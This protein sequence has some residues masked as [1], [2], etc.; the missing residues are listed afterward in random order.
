MGFFDEYDILGG[1]GDLVKAPFKAADEILFGGPGE[2]GG[3]LGTPIKDGLDIPGTALTVVATALTGGLAGSAISRAVGSAGST[4]LRTA[5]GG[6]TN[7]LASPSLGASVGVAAEMARSIGR[8]AP[9]GSLIPIPGTGNQQFLNYSVLGF[10]AKETVQ[11]VVDNDVRDTVK[12]VRGSVVYCDLACVAEHSGIYVGA[13]HIV[14]LDGTGRIELVTYEQFLNRLGGLNTALSV[15]V[16]CLGARSVGSDTVAQRAMAM[17]G[18]QR[19]YNVALDN[20]HQF[21][22]GCI[23]GDFDNADNFWWMLKDTVEF[24]YGADS[25]RVWKT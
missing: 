9:V 23:S 17:I 5:G 15:Y 19:P 1:L 25:W 3:I 16:S 18:R 12:P 24:Q 6:L 11:H 4:A 13:G 14:H 7:T 8:F 22:S 2:V 21:T 20:C 10:V